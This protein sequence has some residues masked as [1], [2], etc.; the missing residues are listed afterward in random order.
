MLIIKRMNQA[1]FVK[2]WLEIP[3]ISRANKEQPNWNEKDSQVLTPVL[4]KSD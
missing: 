2:I 4:A 1:P 3:F